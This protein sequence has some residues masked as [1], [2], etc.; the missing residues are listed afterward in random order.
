MRLLRR[1]GRRVEVQNYI[2]NTGVQVADVVVG[3]Q[4][5]EK[6]SLDEVR[7]L[8]A[9]P[10]FD[11]LCWDLYAR[12]TQFLRGRQ[13]ALGAAGPD[14]GGDRAWPRRRSGT[15][16]DRLRR[17]RALPPATRWSGSSVEYDVLP[18]ESEIL[19]LKFWDA[20][21]EQLK[22]RGAIHL[23]TDRQEFR[24]LGDESCRQRRRH[25]RHRQ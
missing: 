14:A 25:R 19:H 9:A 6:K 12:V 23:A 10:R 22:Q 20:A 4:H 3:F 15:G 24:L 17:H 13:V 2:D 5:I 1:A 8:A 21:F 7:A 11:Y 16:R 18:R